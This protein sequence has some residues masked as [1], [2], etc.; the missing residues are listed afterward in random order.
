MSEKLTTIRSLSKR[1]II[2]L[3]TTLLLISLGTYF[4]FHS[5]N[6]T[7]QSKLKTKP[8]VTVQTLEKKDMYKQ[9]SMF[10]QTVPEAQIDIMPKYSGR[11]ISVNVHLGQQVNAGDILIVQDTGDLDISLQENDASIRQAQADTTQA[12][13]SYDAD[14]QKAQADYERS[15][16]NFVRYQS[17]FEMGAVSKES[18]DSVE[19]QM[20]NAKSTLDNLVNQTMTG[21]IPASVESKRAAL[22]KAERAT[23]A[24]EKQRSDLILRAPRSG[25]IGFR[26]VE[27]GSLVQAGQKLLSLVDNSKIYVD[28]QLSE[29]DIAFVKTGL[30]VTVNVEALGNTYNGIITY[31]S[32][33]V[34]DKT[35]SYTAR[36][37]FSQQDSAIKGGMFARTQIQF[38]QRPQTIFVPK[39]S[40]V[41]KNGKTY[42][43]VINENQQVEERVIST[44]LHNDDSIEI[45]SGV[46]IGERI[47]TSNL[48]RLQN[49]LAVDIENTAGEQI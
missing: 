17:L 36:I 3:C 16:T 48:S 8:S 11:I 20:I 35:K 38:L 45:L 41:D 21:A 6:K 37:E 19:Q 25:I 40:I 7:D 49:N 34:D 5:Q 2:L 27:A 24:L 4:I 12:Q 44:G 29:Q 1:K 46:A 42:A 9:I 23:S 22:T 43:Y 39:E 32:P 14:Y 31:I 47:A 26:S 13:A 10:G 18:L 28:C 30:P 33:A 15:K